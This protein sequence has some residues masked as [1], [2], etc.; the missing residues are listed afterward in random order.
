MIGSI[1]QILF[2]GRDGHLGFLAQRAF[3]GRSDLPPQLL[4]PPA[5]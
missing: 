5:C 4:R 2:E 3:T 1:A